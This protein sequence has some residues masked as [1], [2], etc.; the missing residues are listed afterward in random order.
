MVRPG[1]S[2]AFDMPSLM[3]HDSD[4]TLLVGRGG[5]RGGRGR[6]T[7]KASRQLFD[8]IPLG[9]VSTVDD[10][11]RAGGDHPRVLR[12]GRR[13]PGSVAGSARGDD[14]DRH[15]QGVHRP[16]GVVPPG[17]SGDAAGHR[18]GRVV[19]P[20]MPRWHPISISGYHIREAG[21]TAAQ[22]LAFTLKDGLTY[23]EHV[24]RVVSTSMTSCLRLSFL[25]QRPDRLLRG[26]RR[27]SAPP[28]DLGRELREPMARSPESWRMRFDMQTAGVSLSA[29]AAEQHRQDAIEA[30]VG[31]LGGPS[32]CTRNSLRRGARAA[33]RGGRAG[34]AAD[35]A[36]HR[37]RG[38]TNRSTR[39]AGAYFVE[40]LD[41]PARGAGVRVLRGIDELGGMVDAVKRGFSSAR[42][43]R[44]GVRAGDGIERRS[45]IV[46]GVNGFPRATRPGRRSCASTRTRAAPDRVARGVKAGRRDGRGSAAGRHPGAGRRRRR[47]LS[48][49]IQAAPGLGQRG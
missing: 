4:H 3:G 14:P 39:S 1:L 19:R 37:A 31:V 28:A 25:L 15:P 44:G 7:S 24:V 34:G 18:H 21:S 29:R 12:R 48:G 47:D 30:F 38:V 42:D 36:D 8:G 10:D 20:H 2:T 6:H 35:R 16:E 40:A 5:A 46:V 22:E 13:A 49:A 41:R 26:D 11:Q 43:R 9:D 33:D 23:V 27:K 45:P 32:R 17:R